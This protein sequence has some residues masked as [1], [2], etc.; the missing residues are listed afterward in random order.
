MYILS[1]YTSLF[2]Y[3]QTSPN[4]PRNGEFPFDS[5]EVTSFSDDWCKIFGSLF[6]DFWLGINKN[7]RTVLWWLS[8]SV[9]ASSLSLVVHG[10]FMMLQCWRFWW[11]T[12]VMVPIFLFL[13]E[14]SFLNSSLKH[15][16]EKGRVNQTPRDFDNPN[17][18]IKTLDKRSYQSITLKAEVKDESMVLK[19]SE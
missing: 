13:L 3:S 19:P 18:R 11:P 8:R 12:F 17:K 9:D 4:L 14:S 7:H 5:K 15:W 6:L 2:I 10:N 16:L 1:V